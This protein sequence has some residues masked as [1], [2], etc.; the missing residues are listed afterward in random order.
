MRK[1]QRESGEF[2]NVTRKSA[3]EDVKK[4]W[5]SITRPFAVLFGSSVLMLLSVFAAVAF[6]YFYVMCISFPQVLQEM[7]GFTPAQT[8]SSFMTFSKSA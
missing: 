2:R 8:G 5:H 7:Y 3:R 1:V 6:S 4:L